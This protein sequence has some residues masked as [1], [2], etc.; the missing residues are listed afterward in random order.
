[1]RLSYQH[2]NPAGGNESYLLRFHADSTDAGDA[3]VLVDAG[4]ETELDHLLDPADRLVAICLT[5]AHLDHYQSLE[6]CTREETAIFASPSTASILGDVFD[7]AARDYD[8]QTSDDTVSRI[9]PIDGWTELTPKVEVHPT[10]AGHAPGAVGYLFQFDDGSETHHVLSTGDFTRRR[11]AGFPGF[12]PT[13]FLDIDVLFLTVPTDDTFEENLSKGL[14]QA[15]QRAHSGARTLVATSGVFGVQVVYL[16]AELAADLDREVP[17]HAVGQVAKLYETLDYEYEH[18]KTIPFFDDPQ[19]CLAHGAITIAGPEVPHERSS[20]RLFG[21]LQSE[22][23]AC[24]V[25]MLGSS[26]DPLEGGRC[27]IHSY[28]VQNHP[29]RET[30]YEVHDLIDPQHTVITHRHRGAGSEFNDLNGYVWS[31]QGTEEYS[32][33]D[34]GEWLSPPWMG[35]GPTQ[36]SN[37]QSTVGQQIGDDIIGALSLPSL[38][39]HDAADLAAE[40]VK[41]ELVR[42]IV[43]QRAAY[44]TSDTTQDRD[45]TDTT[46]EPPTK[47]NA[48]TTEIDTKH[49]V[50]DETDTSKDEADQSSPPPLNSTELFDT[51][52]PTT[53]GIDP[54]IVAAL[55]SGDISAEDVSEAIS[56]R[57]N[58]T[59]LAASTASETGDSVEE[60][61]GSPEPRDDDSPRTG[62]TAESAL[63]ETDRDTSSDEE[64][65]DDATGTDTAPE[66][67]AEKPTA[68]TQE[69]EP[70][71]PAGDETA[72]ADETSS[73]ASPSSDARVDGPL[74]AAE[75]QM[76]DESNAVEM[77]LDSL[78]VA[79]AIDGADRAGE[80]SVEAFVRRAV[81]EY[82]QD[83][84]DGT[85]TGPESIRTELAFETGGELGSALTAT[86]ENDDRYQ[87]VEELLRAGTAEAIA[88]EAERTLAI[89][90]L[91]PHLPLIDAV[92]EN[93]ENAITSRE[94]LVTISIQRRV[95]RL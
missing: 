6:A 2:V 43:S 49:M 77:T 22:P 92:T 8:V 95:G 40:G 42:Q 64:G 31:P 74:H 33:Y 29:S 11:A 45:D 88:P 5:H 76:A 51:S 48:N 10:P 13:S 24:V 72:P 41:I 50:P 67:V 94:D 26:E 15:L 30:L 20:G 82:L 87:S 85:I 80:D 27:T 81:R 28:R 34:G 84:L 90:A 53:E 56:L 38:E 86:V 54:A 23:G 65:G 17:I 89:P 62:E 39:R 46:A 71:S 21:L 18:V 35:G 52:A 93:E 83:L 55:E 61:S 47:T 63:T 73:S 75:G 68:D 58:H 78:T 44:T 25:Q 1:V 3:C 59:A 91:G 32:L 37:T 36:S 19:D 69:S 4:A 79:L 16:L 60:S 9:E 57:Q 12:D 66:P 7:V 70:S 14:G